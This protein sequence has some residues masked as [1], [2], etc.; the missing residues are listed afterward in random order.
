[1]F[2]VCAKIDI[3]LTPLLAIERHDGIRPTILYITVRT[4]QKRPPRVVK[5]A[6]DDRCER[7]E[8]RP[9]RAGVTTASPFRDCCSGPTSTPALIR[10]KVVGEA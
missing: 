9:P 5:P 2:W 6:G 8:Q 10:V 3:V 1:L 4:D 7:I